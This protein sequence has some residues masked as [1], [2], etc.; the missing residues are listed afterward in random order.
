M[1]GLQGMFTIRV[2][3]ARLDRRAIS[4]DTVLP[5]DYGL[6]NRLYKGYS[7]HEYLVLRKR[8]PELKCLTSGKR[9]QVSI[10]SEPWTIQNTSRLDCSVLFICS[11]ETLVDIYRVTSGFVHETKTFSQAL[12]LHKGINIVAWSRDVIIE[13]SPGTGR[14]AGPR[15]LLAASSTDEWAYREIACRGTDPPC[16]WTES[17][18]FNWPVWLASHAC[19][20]TP[21][22][23]PWT[24]EQ[25]SILEQLSAKTDTLDF[26]NR[27]SLLRDP[28]VPEGCSGILHE[29]WEENLVQPVWNTYLNRPLNLPPLPD[30]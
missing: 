18:R 13:L 10:K 26:R 19:M 17:C 11:A 28:S 14:F 21:H 3:P 5:G 1:E 25:W 12:L 24:L 9:L 2:D 7:W 29:L 20:V 4:I 27:V 22:G 23:V 16:P 30:F 15:Y 8:Y 6:A